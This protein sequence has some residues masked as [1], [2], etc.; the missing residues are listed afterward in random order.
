VVIVLITTSG[1]S[2][3]T[4]AKLP[5][6]AKLP[7][8]VKAYANPGMSATG[9]LPRDWSAV[10]GNGLLRLANGDGSSV[11]VVASVSTATNHNPPLLSTAMASIRK[12]YGTVTTKHGNGT[13]LGGLQ[14][15]SIVVYARNKQKVPIRILLAVALGHRQAYV[16]E[17]FT[18]QKATTRDLVETQQVV[19]TLRL[20][21]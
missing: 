19:N 8:L 12:T 20:K 16:L 13:V 3:Q 9:L 1:S 18:A 7:T 15:R 4:A 21:G 10:R 11:I 5:P 14:A 6:P 17:A 2:N